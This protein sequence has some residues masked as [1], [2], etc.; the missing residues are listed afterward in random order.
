MVT[1]RRRGSSLCVKSIINL[2]LL[3]GMLSDSRSQLYIDL[4]GKRVVIVRCYLVC[5]R[6]LT[7]CELIK[8]KR[9]LSVGGP[10]QILEPLDAPPCGI[11]RT[12][13]QS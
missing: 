12:Y 11:L 4:V 1:Y 2:E 13:T 3:R 7:S 6:R 10:L 5:S 8:A 9:Q